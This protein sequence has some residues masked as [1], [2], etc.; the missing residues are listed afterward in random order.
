MRI[1]S[2]S[3][4]VAALAF[5]GCGDA[6][7]KIKNEKPV[8]PTTNSTTVSP[9]TLEQSQDPSNQPVFSFDKERHDF[10]EITQDAPVTT[11]FT[12]TNTG[13]APLVISNAKGSCGCTVPNWPRNP[14]QPGET[15]TIEVTFDPKNKPGKQNK[16]VTIT[17]N[18]TPNTK[19]L[20]ISAQ[21][22]Q[23]EKPAQ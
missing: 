23:N 10:G 21:V 9:E 8:E 2:I 4:A 6:S 15:G 14:V 12:F 16:N 19:V 3:L 5:A 1:L 17:A 13:N 7:S 20:N 11:T 18:T 22:A